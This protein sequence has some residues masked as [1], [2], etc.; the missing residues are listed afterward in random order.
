M[1]G[2][3]GSGL[4]PEALV[5]LGETYLKMKQL[6]DAKEAFEAVARDYPESPLVVQ[7]R[8]YLTFLGASASPRPPPSPSSSA[9]P[10]GSDG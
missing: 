4:E 6:P 10:A 2:H 9:A 3:T 1:A 5:L 7:A 8:N